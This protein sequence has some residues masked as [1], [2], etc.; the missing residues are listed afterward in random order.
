MKTVQYVK[1]LCNMNLADNPSQNLENQ[2]F[3]PPSALLD[4][5]PNLMSPQSL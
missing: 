5:A 2:Q 4:A 3:L 1:G